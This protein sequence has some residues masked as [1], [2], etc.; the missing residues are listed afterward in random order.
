MKI[1]ESV[2][3]IQG[4]Y[5]ELTEPVG[6]SGNMKN[7]G[8]IEL[9]FDSNSLL[10]GFRIKVHNPNNDKIH[11]AYQQALRL[12]NIISF[13]TGMVVSHK[14]AKPIIDNQVQEGSTSFT[15]DVV[16]AKQIDLI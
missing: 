7:S 13:K 6:I 14:R 4:L 9:D 8:K 5:F 11:K 1:R 16:I 3:V 12:T 10:K 15:M 2:D